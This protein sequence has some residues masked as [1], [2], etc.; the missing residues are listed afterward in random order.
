M[1]PQ[2]RKEDEPAVSELVVLL[3][4]ARRVRRLA[5]PDP[6][7]WE[8]VLGLT[9]RLANFLAALLS[10]FSPH[11]VMELV[12]IFLRAF[13]ARLSADS[14]LSDRDMITLGQLP[15]DVVIEMRRDSNPGG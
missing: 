2:I 13:L 3:H 8:E 9:A 15:L 11:H 10:N 6:K 1:T 4:E 5:R 7:A 14:K 12:T